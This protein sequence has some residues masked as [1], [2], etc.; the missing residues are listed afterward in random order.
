MPAI[1]R[2]SIHCSASGSR[3]ETVFLGES[4]FKPLRSF[5]Q[6]LQCLPRALGFFAEDHDIVLALIEIEAQTRLDF[7]LAG[8]KMGAR[9][10]IDVNKNSAALRVGALNEFHAVFLKE[11]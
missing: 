3:V 7:A 2:K 1:K 9:Y 10:V 6:L 8:S 11:E 4:W 5:L